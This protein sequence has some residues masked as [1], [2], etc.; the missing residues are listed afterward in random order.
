MA[1][2]RAGSETLVQDPELLAFDK[3]G[4]LIDVHFYW[5]SIIGVRAK[6]IVRHLAPG[7][8]KEPLENLLAETMGLDLQT[9]LLKRAGPV[10]IKPRAFI[11]QVV[12]DA[13]RTRG[14]A[15]DVEQI[16]GFFRDVDRITSERVGDFIKILPGVETFLKKAHEAGIKLAV[17]TT[18]RTDRALETLKYLKIDSLFSA[19]IGG[20]LLK[21][22]KP[23]PETLFLLAERLKV[24]VEKMIM[25]GDHPVDIQMAVNAGAAKGIGVLTGLGQIED[26]QRLPC[27]VVKSFNDMDVIL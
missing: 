11:I 20:D 21:K 3:D 23:E 26:F 5:G 9:G 1:T 18:D 13:L 14:I 25:V 7:S 12:V 15:A 10:G 4:T 22:H 27:A 19:V 17:A 8:P 24:S 2:V 16:D 6:H